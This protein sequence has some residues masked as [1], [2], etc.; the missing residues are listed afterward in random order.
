[1]LCDLRLQNVVAEKRKNVKFIKENCDDIDL[2]LWS[3]YMVK[4]GKWRVPTLSR[5]TMR[6]NL[7]L[8]MF[9]LLSNNKENWKG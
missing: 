7:W 8:N 2:A 4:K 6:I 9:L 3:E 5:F 1:M